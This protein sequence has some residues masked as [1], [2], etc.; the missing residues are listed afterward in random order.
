MKIDKKFVADLV[1]S[2]NGSY[3]FYMNDDASMIEENGKYTVRYEDL[4]GMI[5]KIEFC[6]DMCIVSYVNFDGEYK[7]YAYMQNLSQWNKTT[8]I[9]DLVV[10]L[11]KLEKFLEG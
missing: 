8:F 4:N 3:Q 2:I 1:D 5:Y 7:L 9:I 6:C 10:T 11:M